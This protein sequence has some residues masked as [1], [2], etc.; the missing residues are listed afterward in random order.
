[1]TNIKHTE[2]RSLKLDE[3]KKL[4][5]QKRIKSDSESREIIKKNADSSRKYFPLTS[6]QKN[7]WMLNQYLDDKKVYN[8]PLAITCKFKYEMDLLLVK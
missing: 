5:R 8:V 4:V 3:L 1:M 2:I 7:I 6:A